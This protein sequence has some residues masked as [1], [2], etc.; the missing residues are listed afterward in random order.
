M[1]C[2]G[3]VC[4]VL[5]CTVYCSVQYRHTTVNV[6]HN[7]QSS[8]QESIEV[9]GCGKMSD[10]HNDELIKVIGSQWNIIKHLYPESDGGYG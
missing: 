9:R 6:L 4:T 7:L 1:L 5:Q 10:Q 8:D 2:I 3:V